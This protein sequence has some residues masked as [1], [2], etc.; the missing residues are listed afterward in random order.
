[1]TLKLPSGD[2]FTNKG[3]TSK[4]TSKVVIVLK[5]KKMIHSGASASLTSVTLDNSNKQIVS[6]VHIVREFVNIFL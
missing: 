6:S 3:A 5:A 1:M 4:R 2:K